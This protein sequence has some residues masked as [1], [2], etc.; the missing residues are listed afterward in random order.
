M[1]SPC[2]TPAR[3]SAGWGSAAPCDAGCTS[4]RTAW[5]SPTP[6]TNGR[7]R[8]RSASGSAQARR[9]VASRTRGICQIVEDGI[10]G[11]LVP[12]GD[13]G[14]LA[15]ALESF[16]RA[17]DAACR[18]GEN[19]ELLVREEFTWARVVAA[20]ESVYDEVLGLATF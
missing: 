19:G 12:P 9:V 14:A 8:A 10:N 17:P 3:P 16:H 6:K 1:R 11:R 20:Y 2:L 13:P 15:A 18:L 5:T 4:C 7:R